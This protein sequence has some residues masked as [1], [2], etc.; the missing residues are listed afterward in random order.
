MPKL[1]CLSF[2]LGIFLVTPQESI[3]IREHKGLCSNAP[4]LGLTFQ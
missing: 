4:W 3:Q 1:T 2:V